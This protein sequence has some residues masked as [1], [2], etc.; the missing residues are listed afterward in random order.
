MDYQDAYQRLLAAAAGA[1]RAE[2][3]NADDP[4]YSDW[5]DVCSEE[6]ALAARDYVRAVDALPESSQPYGWNTTTA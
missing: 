5:I 6:L 4:H 2:H 1:L 3:S